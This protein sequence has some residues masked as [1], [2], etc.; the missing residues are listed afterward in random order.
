[1]ADV[2]LLGYRWFTGRECIGLVVVDNGFEHKAYIGVGE[3]N[4]QNHD[5]QHIMHF[6]TSF[7]IDEAKRLV[8]INEPR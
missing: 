1:M 4:D 5:L 8:G 3:G 7:P 6:G 2:T